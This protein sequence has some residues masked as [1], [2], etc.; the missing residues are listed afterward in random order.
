MVKKSGRNDL[1]T[2]DASLKPA[3]AVVLE[4]STATHSNCAEQHS[5]PHTSPVITVI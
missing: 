1:E 2:V 5:E 3:V 4:S